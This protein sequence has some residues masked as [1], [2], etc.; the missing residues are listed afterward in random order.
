MRRKTLIKKEKSVFCPQDLN[1]KKKKDMS[2]HLDNG[3]IAASAL[4]PPRNDSHTLFVTLRLVKDS[5][6]KPEHPVPF[7]ALHLPECSE[8]DG[9]YR[10][11]PYG[12]AGVKK[13]VTPS[14]PGWA[15]GGRS[16]KLNIFEQTG[17][18]QA[19]DYEWKA[20]VREGHF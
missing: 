19:I 8:R 2:M 17:I 4:W 9:L 10:T 6:T 12:I 3:E 11:K 16:A 20:V 1:A 5:L 7:A 15:A 14:P 18:A 13:G